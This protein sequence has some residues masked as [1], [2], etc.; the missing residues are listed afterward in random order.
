MAR[1]EISVRQP[2]VQ[3]GVMVKVKVLTYQDAE[4][5]VRGSMLDGTLLGWDDEAFMVAIDGIGTVWIRE[6]QL[7]LEEDILFHRISM[8]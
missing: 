5:K 8:N 2:T 3:L 6:N 1:A 7:V 4:G